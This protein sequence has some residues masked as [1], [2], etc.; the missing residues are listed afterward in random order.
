MDYNSYITD[1]IDNNETIMLKNLLENYDNYKIKDII[2]YK[3]YMKE[4]AKNKKEKIDNYLFQKSWSKLSNELKLIKI[5]EYIDKSLFKV[6]KKN[7][8]E[9]KELIINKLKNNKLKT[10]DVSYEIISGKI[11]NIKG[12]KYN[13]DEKIYTYN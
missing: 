9:I 8:D 10:S 4:S 2:S 7:L 5:N 6:E 11:L 1:I 12:I 3:K 13:N